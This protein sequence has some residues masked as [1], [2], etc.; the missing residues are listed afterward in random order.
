M[1]WVESDTAERIM[2]VV[3]R[4]RAPEG[5]DQAGKAFWLSVTRVYELAPAELV[6][7]HRACVTIGVLAA[8]DAEIAGQGLSVRGSRGQ[9]IPNRMIKLR[10]EV[11]RV[12]DIQVRSLNLPMAGEAEGRR[13]SPAAAA[14]AY[15][16][17]AAHG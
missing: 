2:G 4:P 7:L 12:L 13:R 17:W 3:T 1:R 5:L 11:E 16:R 14:A 15:T 8:M 10:C 9:V 6:G